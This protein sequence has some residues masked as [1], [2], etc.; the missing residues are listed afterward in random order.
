[1]KTK[2]WLTLMTVAL[3]LLAACR[4]EMDFVEE[5]FR[6]GQA[7]ISGG[8][9]SI[10]MLFSSAS[11]S[12]SI[13][14]TANR[15]WEA[16]FVNDRAK[17]WC[18]LSAMSGSRGTVTLT[19]QVTMNGEYDERSASILFTCDDVTRTIVVTQKQKDALLVT[20]SRVDVPQAGG[21]FLVE[22]LS[23]IEFSHELS[24]PGT[25]APTGWIHD[26]GTKALS[27]RILTFQ[28]DP[29]ETIEGREGRLTVRSGLGEEVVRF[30]QDGEI[31]TL[32]VSTHAEEIGPEG[33]YFDVQVRSNLDVEL[34]LP[35]NAPWLT[36]ID[37]K[38]FSTNTYSF[39]VERNELRMD[40][41]CLL[42]FRNPALAMADTVQV[43]QGYQRIVLSDAFVTIPNR[44]TPFTIRVDG[45]DPDQFSLKIS[46]RWIEQTEVEVDKEGTLF[47]FLA[48]ANGSGKE[49]HS[50]IRIYY[51]DFEQPDMV[52]VTQTEAMPGFS[53]TTNL[54]EARV[55]TLDKPDKMTFVFWGDGSY[56]C[57]EEGLTHRY[58]EDGPHTVTIE[59]RKLSDIRFPLPETGVHYDFSKLR[60][61]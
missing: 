1:M 58:Q 47:H 26:L 56:E 4:P 51:K 27:Q 30:Y 55:P 57:Y 7:E 54:R 28:V 2:R 60:N 3:W 10:G 17:N 33:G 42:V 39:S 52:S 32:V 48:E 38:T 14:L 44:Q 24:Y 5:S 59:G 13:D 50:S 16:S 29:N 41:S 25:G 9:T 20:S 21:T 23:N 18:T 19:V 11:G 61:Q 36:E 34:I 49:R 22:V 35:E 43:R 53:Y 40:R 12:A 6:S 37:T 31:P 45:Q 8:A 15:S 46:D